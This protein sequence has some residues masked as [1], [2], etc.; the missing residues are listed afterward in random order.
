MEL[1]LTP[2]VAVARRVIA[3][4]DRNQNGLMARRSDGLC[5]RVRATS[6]LKSTAGGPS[7][8][9]ISGFPQWKLLAGA[10]A[11]FSSVRGHDARIG[12]GHRVFFRNNHRPTSAPTSRIT[13]AGQR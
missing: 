4:I 1:D 8:R 12:A 6:A 9:S 11:R 5:A 7:G 2:G 13:G 10:K 3:D